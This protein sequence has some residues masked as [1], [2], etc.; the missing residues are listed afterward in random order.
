M[1][2]TKNDILDIA[3]GIT[4]KTNPDYII[5]IP[6]PARSEIKTESGLYIPDSASANPGESKE[7]AVVS[8]GE[9]VSGFVS[10]GDLVYCRSGVELSFLDRKSGCRM[11][12]YKPEFVFASYEKW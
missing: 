8:V 5:C 2:V 10:V 7:C 12:I 1:I 11:Y 6:L 3:S 4:F 9:N